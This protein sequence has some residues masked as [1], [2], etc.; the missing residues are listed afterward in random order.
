MNPR[1]IFQACID[2]YESFRPSSI[3]LDTHAERWIS[4]NMIKDDEDAR[5]ISDVLYGCVR[6]KELV[7]AVLSSFYYNNPSCSR[8]ERNIYMILSYLAAIRI[9][10]IGFPSYR[11]LVLA[12]D[13]NKMA[14]F[15]RFLFNENTLNTWLKSEWYTIY[16]PK[17]VE[18]VLIVTIAKY[19]PDAN[20]LIHQLEHQSSSPRDATEEERVVAV[21]Q[22][23]PFNLTR[24]KVRVIP[25]PEAIP[26]SIKAKPVPQ[27]TYV[28]SD[29]TSVQL[30]RAKVVNRELAKKKYADPSAQPFQLK[31]IERPT[32]AEKIRAQVEAARMKEMQPER[33]K[34]VSS[35]SEP[36]TVRLN[37][38]AILREDA[39]YKKR[40]EEEARII[41]DYERHLRDT[42]AFSK[43]KSEMQTLD[44]EKRAA[45]IE[46]RRLEMQ[47]SA[48]E[49]IEARRKKEEENRQLA[50]KMKEQLRLAAE[51]KEIDEKEKMERNKQVVESVQETRD[52][53]SKLKKEMEKRNQEEARE[54]KRIQAELERLKKEEEKEEM[55]KK[56]DLIRQI[57]A[58]ENVPKRTP[59]VIDPTEVVGHGL[60]GEMSI[61]ELKDRLAMQKLKYEEEKSSKRQEI[62]MAK[63]EKDQELIE[64]M[65]RLSRLHRKA[66]DSFSSRK[67]TEKAREAGEKAVEKAKKDEKLI[68][69]Q[70]K[71]EAKRQVRRSE[72][73]KLAEERKSI[74]LKNQ[75][76]RA[77]KNNIEEKKFA[78]QEKGLE[79][80]ARLRQMQELERMKL[81]KEIQE[82]EDALRDMLRAKEEKEKKKAQAAYDESMKTKTL[83]YTETLEDEY[84]RKKQHAEQEHA[85]SLNRSRRSQSPINTV[86]RPTGSAGASRKSPTVRP[87]SAKMK[88]ALPQSA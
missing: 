55:L 85:R 23:Q 62:I 54:V 22:V 64:K 73:E 37:A 13:A 77:D 32:N 49:A 67:E 12:H 59:K 58:L 30:E 63:K 69:L 45:E 40:L 5:F 8:A 80:A 82:K 17:Y 42:S 6:Y 20:N 18:D 68:A 87:P 83:E 4:E 53:A 19:I 3:T 81:E 52:N 88:L 24:P 47:L 27:S 74:M 16:D 44:D 35:P 51:R 25:E 39:R 26:T 36:P 78:Q 34:I 21:T 28:K 57:R 46:R 10:D 38:A 31:T 33:R 11:R 48:E 60:L 1:D 9:E 79:R 2:I 41:L 50:E 56:E 29:A 7:D 14:A 75:F 43:W 66:E 76:L 65:E 71:L 15:L 72:Q 70:E 86:S 84:K 61:A